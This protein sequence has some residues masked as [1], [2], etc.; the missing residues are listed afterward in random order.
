MTEANYQPEGAA[1]GAGQAQAAPEPE[2]SVGAQLRAVREQQGLSVIDVAQ[3]L[4][5]SLIHI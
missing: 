3:R 4:K 5:L 2:V 1:E